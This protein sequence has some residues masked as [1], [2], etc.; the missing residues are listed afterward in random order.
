MKRATSLPNLALDLVCWTD[1]ANRL[2]R[3]Y[4]GD[5]HKPAGYS[6][7]I[8]LWYEHHINIR[9]DAGPSEISLSNRDLSYI[10]VTY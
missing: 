1:T 3:A 7:F 10:S 8:V 6:G 4:D 5:K 2:H 9:L